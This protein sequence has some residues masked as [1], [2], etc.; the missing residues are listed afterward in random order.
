MPTPLSSTEI[1][2]NSFTELAEILI[3]LWVLSFT[4]SIAFLGLFGFSLYMSKQR[5]KEMG[6]RKTF[7]ANVKDILVLFS[8]EYLTLT[9]FANLLAWPIAYW[10]TKSWLANYSFRID[11]P[12][13]IYVIVIIIS[14]L[15]ISL[16]VSIN[17]IRT[18]NQNPSDIL[19]YE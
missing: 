16:I 19:R 4:A 6:I 14:I 15:F 7:G 5:N 18:A 3:S 8:K 1:N 11:Y 9:I 10:L 17:T 13:Y 12:L 2:D